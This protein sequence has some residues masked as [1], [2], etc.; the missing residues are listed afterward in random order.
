MNF[1]SGAGGG[2]GSGGAN[3][4]SDLQEVET[5][6]LSFQGVSG[7]DKLRLLPSPW[8]P[9]NLPPPTSSLLSVAPRKGLVAAA[10]P[11]TLVIASA[12][13]LRHSFINGEADPSK[14]KSFS[15]QATIS[16]PRL[17]QV[18]FSSDESC[19]IIS[20]EQG[21]GLA[22]YDT[23]AL[24][25][26]GKDAAFQ[27]GT[28]GQSVRQLLPNPNPSA[29]TS[30][31]CGI[32]T[33][34]GL[35]LLADLKDRKLVNTASGSAIF[36]Q[37]VSCACWSR[38]G[39]QIIAGLADG[40][41]AQVDQQGNVKGT[42]PEPP[43]LAGLKDPSAQSYPIT[44]I[45]WLETFDFLI[46]HT[47][48]NPPDAMGQDDS[49]YHLA[50]KDKASGTWTFSKFPDPC[51]PFGA[52]RK[53]AYHFVQR[54]RDWPPA[55]TDTLVLA[56]TAS[57]DVGVFTR[58]KQP[59]GEDV[60]APDTFT[61]TQPPEG[62]RAALP[63]GAAS[64]PSA[65]GV[66]IDLST[67]E[68]VNRPIPNDEELE[69][70]PTPL[71]A[72]YILNQ[73]G[74][75]SM[76]WLVYNDSI[77][78]Q[79]P[80]P[81]LIA[82]GGPRA[83]QE[84]AA[85]NASTPAAAPATGT[86]AFG[87]FSGASTA[88]P[89][90]GQSTFGSASSMGTSNAPASAAKPA[91]GQSSF[92]S[93]SSMGSP[94]APAF[95]KPS[96]PT[97]GGTS[98][99][100]T[101]SPWAKAAAPSP[102]G[103]T[104]KPAFGQSTFGQASA[105]G[106]SSGFGQAGALGQ[107]KSPWTSGP[108]QSAQ[109]PSTTTGGGIF[110]GNASG[111]S[112]F[113]NMGGKSAES[114]APASGFS[115]FAKKEN[116][117]SP[118]S[119]KPSL[120]A[121]PSGS[122]VSFGT[123]S[124]FG[125]GTSL[126]GGQ[127][128]PSAF[129]TPAQNGTSTFGK[130]SFGQGGK[131]ETMEDD[132]PA[133]PAETA[134]K[135]PFGMPSGG[136]KLG[137]TFKGDG[138]AKD[139]LPKPRD[140]GAAFFGN[141]FGNA[142]GSAAQETPSIKKEPDTEDA[143]SLKDIP[144]AKSPSTTPKAAPKEQ[145]PSDDAPL[146]PDPTTWKPKDGAPPPP[147]PPGFG[148]DFVKP[149]ETKSTPEKGED[150]PLPPDFTKTAS[151]A[152]EKPVAG[153]PPVD[154][155]SEKFS[156]GVGSGEAGPPEDDDDV[157]WSEEEDEDEDEDE[158]EG[159]DDEE[160]VIEDPK[161]LAAFQSRITPASPKMP[162]ESPETQPSTT[163]ATDQKQSYTPAGLPKAPVMFPPPSKAVQDSPR[164]PSPV[165]NAT[166]PQRLMAQPFSSSRPKPP[167]S[168]A[169]PVSRSRQPSQT[170]NVSQGPPQRI[171][172]PPAQLVAQEQQRSKATP[173]PEEPTAGQLQDEEDAQ[174]QEILAAPIEPTREVPSFLAHQ[175]Y[176]GSAQAA[177]DG[178]TSRPGLGSQIERV[179]RDINSMIDT[180]ALNARG[181]QAFIQGNEPAPVEEEKD[182]GSLEDPESWVLD[183][184]A[185]LQDVMQALDADLQQEQL[186]NV[187][188]LLEDIHDESGEAQRLR[189]R[190]TELRKQVNA[191]ADPSRARE[192]QLASLPL[193]SASQQSE[194][195]QG[196]QKVQTMLAKA[197]EQLSLLRAELASRDQASKQSNQTMPTVEAVTNTITKMT[198][199]I[200]KRSGDVDVLESAI[201]RL[202]GLPPA[203][204]S[205]ADGYEDDLAG[206]MKASRLSYGSPVASPAPASARRSVMRQS[207]LGG[208]MG[209]P[210]A[211]ARKQSLMH[212]DDE[213]V[214]AYRARK[215]ARRKVCSVLRDDV[216]VGR[217]VRVTR[218]R[219]A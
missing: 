36:H 16:V 42:I 148:D 46:I 137:S 213:A 133:K 172:V 96:T 185:R 119:T 11:D 111:A 159:E 177:R 39:K 67:K 43:Q 101:Q 121:E 167:P 179:F 153:S 217:G 54:L 81:D 204:V 56:S 199:M 88:K 198:A 171:A 175:D 152:S 5:E 38:L 74:T 140:A 34:N 61:F 129:G 13:S 146:P 26:G 7:D 207:R 144:E 212:P 32:V 218:V 114:G 6:R 102:F 163:P 18:A 170:S 131:E 196:V 85:G 145:F 125:S 194:I 63:M 216:L 214:E 192:Q 136:F 10:A 25:S 120:S 45:Y 9:D 203:K 115:A 80:Y 173:Q 113:T 72:L 8:P 76:W 124:S 197:E 60:S 147:I 169:A 73:E 164:S 108:Q 62:R 165:R 41:G 219:D 201:R 195:R 134:S 20:A 28:E 95:G 90:F 139:D 112:P 50:H 150:A 51:P 12:D 59:L 40:T 3:A 2:G 98:A 130:P 23:G 184:A 206:A 78:Q 53:P 77:R 211:S 188:G 202:G 49:I 29:D 187:R 48:I 181:M 79:L 37:N 127:Q 69:K 118:F 84:K 168:P 151:N 141:A 104:S 55:L 208:S 116:Q 103:S 109:S 186:E 143:P 142:L 75:L 200:E 22:V 30:R 105:P 27:L 4:G 106:G 33:S 52:D 117:P 176:V 44:A 174:V 215:E 183:G 182:V 65:I 24:T 189:T 123:G 158:D 154:L 160:A 190:M 66:A 138:T 205:L 93:S 64:D 191:H 68:N 157:E 100:G 94:S 17:S 99:I 149:K 83:L 58:S 126:F 110:G 156:E 135:S 162:P 87:G 107:N 19:L 15:P 71:P 161:A 193:E 82:A 57:S 89:A 97:F 86:G 210:G 21:G 47:P 209:T 91:F 92:G 14:I 166:S 155:G 31:Y 35:L 180:L 128:T 70:S 178:A 1:G 132:T 122:T